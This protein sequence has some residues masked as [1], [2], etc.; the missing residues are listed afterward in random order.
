MRSPGHHRFEIFTAHDSPHSGAPEIVS[1]IMA[2]R[3]KLYQI[4]S[5][6]ANGQHPHGT[7]PRVSF[8]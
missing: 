6:R 7:F 8:L 1:L 4:F 3:G 5:R 2:D